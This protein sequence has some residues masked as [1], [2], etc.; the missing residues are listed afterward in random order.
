M[1]TTLALDDDLIS[2]RGGPN[3]R[4]HPTNLFVEAEIAVGGRCGVEDA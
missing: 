1:R 2:V 4:L 3:G